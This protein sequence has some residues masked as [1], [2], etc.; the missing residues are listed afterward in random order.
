MGEQQ[1]ELEG[2]VRGVVCG[3]AGR[4][5]VAIPRQRQGIDREEDQKVILAQGGDQG[6]F[7]ECET[8]GYGLAI[9]PRA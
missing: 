5:G 3:P 1:C 9:E 2:D 7:V 4:E 6:A 8:D